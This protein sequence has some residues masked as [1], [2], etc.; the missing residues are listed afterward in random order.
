MDGFVYSQTGA[1]NGVI[2][3]VDA[4]GGG[5][6]DGALE[7]ASG[8]S[9]GNVRIWDPRQKHSPVARFEPKTDVGGIRYPCTAIA[10]G[11]ANNGIERCICAGYDNGDVK[12]FDLRTMKIR[13]QTHINSPICSIDIDNKSKSINRMAVGTSF[14]GIHLFDFNAQS[15]DDGVDK[16]SNE[17]LTESLWCVRYLPQ[18]TNILAACDHNGFVHLFNLRFVSK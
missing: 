18:N 2:N 6:D 4:I 16:Y 15:P 7:M 13:W 14:K 10:F 3:C 5:S 17:K 8:G 12:L 1:H 11:N 9:D